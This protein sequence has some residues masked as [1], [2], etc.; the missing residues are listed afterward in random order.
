MWFSIAMIVYHR[1]LVSNILGKLT[2][3]VE[4]LSTHMYKPFITSYVRMISTLTL[5]VDTPLLLGCSFRYTIQLYSQCP[6]EQWSK[7]E[8]SLLSSQQG[9][10]FH[11]SVFNDPQ[12]SNY[13]YIIH[14]YIY[15]LYIYTY[16]YIIHLYIYIYIYVLYIYTCI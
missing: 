8:I 9:S 13:I 14:L 4:I 6:K 12:R 15:I 1:V 16:V 10:R 7:P 5:D 3:D 11:G 2:L